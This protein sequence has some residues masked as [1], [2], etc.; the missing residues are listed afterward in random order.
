MHWGMVDMQTCS[1][2]ALVVAALSAV[3]I[4]AQAITLNINTGNTADFTALDRF[5]NSAPPLAY[6]AQLPHGIRVAGVTYYE[7]LY[8][9]TL[10]AGFSNARLDWTDFQA[11]DRAVMFLNGTALMGVGINGPGIGSIQIAPT[12]SNDPFL[13]SAEG[14]P[15][16]TT[17]PFI[18]GVNTLRFVVNDTF[19]GIVGSIGSDVDSLTVPRPTVD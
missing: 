9:F 8:S 2:I 17:G 19:S 14:T 7:I 11:D 10:P 12:L 16:S 18:S 15:G 4:P 6:T 5:G 3:A 13:F 1:K